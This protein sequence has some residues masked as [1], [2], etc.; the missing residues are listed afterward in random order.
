MSHLPAY[1]SSISDS[2]VRDP[3]ACVLASALANSLDYLQIF[4]DFAVA[5]SQRIVTIDRTEWN[6][7]AWRAQIYPTD[8]LIT[9]P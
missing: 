2:P 9:L 5:E 3:A 8:T 4:F 7:S 6:G 1:H